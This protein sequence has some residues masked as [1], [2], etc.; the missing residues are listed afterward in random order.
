MKKG[1]TKL[2]KKDFEEFHVWELQNSL[3]TVE[4]YKGEIPFKADKFRVFFVRAKFILADKS[5]ILGWIMICVPPYDV[6]SLSPTIITDAGP[7]SLT[8]S[9]KQSN[10]KN[11]D[12]SF[13]RLGKS[14]SKIFP[15]QFE[16]AV[17]VP[18]GPVT[19]EM[20][21]FLHRLNF[22]D[23][24]GWPQ[25]VDFIYQT[26]DELEA[27]IKSY[28]EKETARKAA[29]EPSKEEK[30]LLKAA[31]NGDATKVKM[32]LSKGVNVNRGGTFEYGG[33]YTAKGVTALMLAAENGQIEVLQ[34]LIKAGADIHLAADTNEPRAG[35]KTALACACCAEQIEAACLLLEAGA[36]PND[37]LSF[38][39]IV[40][41]EICYEK[42]IEVIQFLLGY[43][44]NPD[45]SCGKMLQL[46]TA[47]LR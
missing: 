11:L 28:N 35:G 22:E 17:P 15:L 10:Q 42:S 14:A 27:A 3:T 31:K 41:D 36:N 29:L 26:A 7:V 33:Y 8:R 18:N 6:Y 24:K 32:L 5:K 40:F 12:E 38:G 9:L 4:P 21:V 39:H 20:S 13:R 43:G 47:I 34:V 37:K 45:A 2:T 30:A 46:K 23:E 19:V 25:H 44:A 1:F 16:T